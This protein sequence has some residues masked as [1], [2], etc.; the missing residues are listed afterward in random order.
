MRTGALDEARR[1]AEL[2]SA[3]RLGDNRKTLGYR[4]RRSA[5]YVCAT[6]RSAGWSCELV[7]PAERELI[8]AHRATATA[9]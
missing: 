9:A 5:S 6:L 3:A 7:S 8:R 1:R 4:N 2:L